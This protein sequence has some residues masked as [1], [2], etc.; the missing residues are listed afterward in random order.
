MVSAPVKVEYLDVG[1]TQEVKFCAGIFAIHQHPDGALE[2]R[3]GWA[4]VENETASD[5][6]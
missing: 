4:V 5:Q 2:P 1:K 3:T 6:Q